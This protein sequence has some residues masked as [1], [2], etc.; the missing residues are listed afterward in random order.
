MVTF[1]WFLE[2]WPCVLFILKLFI[3]NQKQLATWKGN[4]LS[5]GGRA[6]LIKAC[7]SCLPLFFMSLFPAPMRV[8]EKI[9][10][11]QRNFLWNGDNE[12]KRLAPVAWSNVET[13]KSLCG[14][15]IGNIHHKNLVLLLAKWVRGLF[16]EP[17]PLWRKLVF[18]K[19]GYYQ[20]FTVG[21]LQIPKK[22]GTWR[23]I[24]HTL[25]SHPQSR[26]MLKSLIRKRI[27]GVHDTLFWHD[28]WVGNTPLKLL[29]PRLFRASLHKNAK[30]AY[31]CLWDGL[32]WKWTLN[33]A[34]TL[35]PQDNTELSSLL[36]LL[37]EVHLSPSD[38]DHLIWTPNENG[39][40]SVKSFSFELAKRNI[41][42]PPSPIPGL[43]K[44]LVSYRAEIF[45]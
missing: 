32:E 41:T 5:T 4:L 33:W 34:R 19:Y 37:R 38:P 45:V 27:G 25:L 23:N 11:I 6:T 12:R 29:F 36:L 26:I 28:V 21:D 43:W 2:V 40:F 44:G 1:D 24:C 20:Q 39:C 16:N 7:L 9:R 15:N 31:V 18:E 13:P 10:I 17:H 3:F 22:G 35:R 42:N 30:V 14:L 8:I